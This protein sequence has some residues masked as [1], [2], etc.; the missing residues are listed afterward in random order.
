MKR[1]NLSFLLALALLLAANAK[2][3]MHHLN[4][5]TNTATIQNVDLSN[6][7]YNQS[8][9]ESF[10]VMEMNLE[11]DCRAYAVEGVIDFAVDCNVDIGEAAALLYDDL[12]SDC[13]SVDGNI[14][15]PVNIC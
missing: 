3:P 7:V 4:A 6:L 9:F 8:F 14:A 12:Y 10:P 15:P 1:I 2:V 11:D 13:M 5:K